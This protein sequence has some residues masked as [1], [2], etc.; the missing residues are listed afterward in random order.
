[1]VSGNINIMKFG[2]FYPFFRG[3]SHNRTY[4]KEP[5]LYD[6]N[7]LDII[8]KSIILRYKLLPFIYTTFYLY[9]KLGTPILRPTWFNNIGSE[10]LY[11]INN[12]MLFGDSILIRPVVSLIEHERNE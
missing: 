9:Y 3:H 4:R 2:I 5:W 12:Q 8:R 6:N 11:G 10:Y 1:M 7:T